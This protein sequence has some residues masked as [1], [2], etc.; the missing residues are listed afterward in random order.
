MAK[1]SGFVNK[2][3]LQV[4]I[5]AVDPTNPYPG[6]LL[7]QEDYYIF[8]NQSNPTQSLSI[9][10]LIIQKTKTGWSIRGYDQY[11]PYFTIYQ[12]IA[13]TS[14]QELRVGGISSPYTLWTANTKYVAGQ[15]VFYGDRY[16]TVVTNH[17]SG[18]TFDKVYYQ[19]LPYLP[20]VG[21]IAVSDRKRFSS[22]ETVIPYGIE[23][24]TV[25]EVYDL[26]IGY[27]AW[28]EAQGFVFDEYNNDLQKVLNWSF[29]GTEFLYWVTQGWSTD[30]IITISPF[31]N[32]LVFASD[33][34][35]VDSVTNSFYQ[36]SIL[37]ADGTPFPQE[38]LTFVRLDGQF[39]ASTVN[40]TDGIFFAR[41]NVVQK[42]HA[43]VFNNFSMFNDVVY[44]DETGYRQFRV[45]L[46]G[47][48]TANW[49]GDFFSPGFIFDEAAI[50][51]WAQYTDYTIGDVVLFNG[52][53]YSALASIPGSASFDQNQW[54]QLSQAPQP[55]LLG[56][57]DYKINQ[58]QDFY[59]LDIDNFDVAQQA[60]AQHLTGYTPR[61]YLN[62]IIGDPIAQYK[63]YQ[64]MI[65]EKGTRNA[66]SKIARA[67]L[68]NLQS[69]I[70]YNEEWAFRIGQY[71]GFNTY[72][73]LET[74]LGSAKFLENPQIIE[75]VETLP[76]NQTDA[77][78]Y[79]TA[80]DIPVQPNNFN[81][82]SVFPTTA[83][84]FT[85]NN[86]ALP[87]A[88]YVRFDDVTA[89][90]YNKN[91]VLDIASNSALM[92]GDTIWLGYKED[93]D[94]DV[95]RVTQVPT[96]I[97]MV[98]NYL[99]NQTVLITTYFPHQLS[100]NDLISISRIGSGID[101]C[102]V[103]QEIINANQFVV[104]TTLLTIPTFTS[105][106]NGL[107]FSFKSIRLNKFDDI[108][109]IPF[110][111]RWKDGELVWVDN[112]GSD[113][114]V[115]YQKINN[116][117]SSTYS[118]GII[119]LG[120][121]FGSTIVT[122]NST[123]T[124]LA[125]APS[126]TDDVGGNGRVFVLTQN[127]VTSAVTNNFSFTLNDSNGDYYTNNSN[128][129]GFGYSMAFNTVTTLTVIGAPLTSN[130]K[131]VTVGT[132]GV[133]HSSNSANSYTKQGAVKLSI[134]D[135]NLAK[136]K[137]QVV[138]TTPNPNN[139]TEFGASVYLSDNTHLLVGAPGENSAYVYNIAVNLV[140]TSSIITQRVSHTS[141]IYLSDVSE[142]E[143]GYVVT[144]NDTKFIVYSVNNDSSITLTTS[145]TGIS[146]GTIAT[147]VNV[148]GGNQIFINSSTH[149]T[150]P[151]VLDSLT[152]RTFGASVTGNADFS[153]YA[154][155]DTSVTQADGSGNLYQ[156]MVF[157]Y[158]NNTIQQI[159]TM[160]DVNLA[161]RFT[162]GDGFAS[163]ISMSKD[164]NYLAIATPQAFDNGLRSGVVDVYKWSTTGTFVWNQTVHA[165]II[166][167]DTRF[168]QTVGFNEAG[169]ILT[170]TSVG[171]SKSI[172]TTFDTYS[173]HL[174]NSL[175]KYGSGYVN[176]PASKTR[177]KQTT[178][179]SGSTKFHSTIANAGSAHVYNRSE[180]GN[181]WIYA[182]EL[183]STDVVSDS[184]FGGSVA[185]TDNLIIVGAPGNSNPI[186]SN[187]SI[188]IFEKINKESNSWLAYRQQED[189][190]DITQIKKTVTID[191]TV[192]Q[193]QD[194]IDIIDPIKGKLLGTSKQELKY[195]SLYDPAIYSLGVVG[196][197]VDSNTN[198]LDEHVGELWWDVSTVKYVWYE[199]GELDYRKNNWNNIFPGCSIDV[200]EWVRSENLPSQW[201]SLADTADGLAQGISGQP[202]FADNSVVS[203]KQV[204]SSVSNSFTNVYYFWVKNKVT[205]PANVP[206]R[207]M[208][209]FE[210]A[211]QIGD[212]V[213]SGNEFMAVIGPTALMLANFK[214]GI[215]SDKYNL[216][217]AFDADS[218]SAPRHTEWLLVQENDNAGIGNA[219]LEKKLVDS[220]VGY[221]SLGNLVPD[222]SLPT[223][224]KYGIG[225]RPQQTMFVDRFEA[226]RNIVEFSNSV[227][228]NQ[229]ITKLINFD[230]LNAKDPIPEV[231][232]Y[233]IAVEDI[234]GLEALSTSAFGTATLTSTVDSNGKIISIN[235]TN[236]GAGYIVPPLITIEGNSTAKLQSVINS[237]GQ[238]TSVTII[239]S[240]EGFVT[241]PLLLVRPFTV[242]VKTDSTIGGKWAVYQW[243]VT[244]S[245]WVR[246]RT[247]SYD[248]T[249]YWDY[250]DWKA[251]SYDPLKT[252][253]TTVPEPYVLNV[254]LNVVTGDY[255]KV[256]NDGTNNY[257]ILRKTDGTGG[258][259]DDQ[260]DLVYAQNGTIQILD[261]IWNYSS[262]ASTADY[263]WDDVGYDQTEY[264]Q[265][266]G[267]EV[268]YIL[269][270]L[271]NDIFINE[272]KVYWNQLFFKA[273]RY[274]F[275][276]QQN[277]DWAFKTTFINVVNTA[278]A[279]DQRTTYKFYN[280]DYYQQYLEEVK[281]YHT[282]IRK[283]TDN[284]TATEFTQSF[285]SDFD[286][287]AFYNTA[288][289]NFNKVE[290]GD[291]QL[292]VYPWKAWF[293]NYTCGI[294]SIEISDGGSGYTIPPTVSII[295]QSGDTGT[296]AT[297]VAYIALG[298]VSQ[299]IVT[300]PGKGYTATPMIVINGGGDTNLVKA[301]ATA[302]LTNPLVRSNMLTMKF[303]RVVSYTNTGTII[304][305]VGSKIATD[306]FIG[307]G[308]TLDFQ[309]T[310]VP[311]PDKANITLLRNGVLQLT[312]QYTINY[313]SRP[314]SPQ[315][316]TTYNKEYAKLV[317]NFI[318][319]F[320]DVIK[321]TY[322]KSLDLYTAIDR[323]EDYYAPATGMPGV[324]P[325]QLMSG[326]SFPGLNVDTLP[327]S[328]AAGWDVIPFG[329][330]AWD[331]YVQEPGYYSTST[332][333][334]GTQTFIIPQ[335]IPNGVEMNIYVNGVRIDGTA[336]GSIV[337]TLTGIGSGVVDQINVIN[338]GAGY[339][340]D[341][342]VNISSPNTLGG[343]DS[344]A[345]ITTATYQLTEGTIVINTWTNGT[346]YTST[347]IVTIGGT[348]TIPAYAQA[349]VRS[350]FV[351]NGTTSSI[352]TIPSIAFTS[353]STLIEFRYST[354]D[355]TVLPT[356]LI[357]LDV[358]LSGGNLTTSTTGF[359][360]AIGIDPNEI[361]LDGW[362]FLDPNYSY[363]PEEHV[364]GQVQESISIN[365]YTQS[366]INSPLIVNKKY[367]VDG[368]TS[369]FALGLTPVT[370]SSVVALLN[371][372]VIDPSHYYIDYNLDTFTFTAP[373]PGTGWLSLTTMQLGT[374]TV[375]D[376]TTVTDA[377]TTSTTFTSGAR[378]SEVGSSFITVNGIPTTDYTVSS[379]KGRARFT[380]LHDVNP[381]TI[382]EFSFAGTAQSFSVV[383]E[384]IIISTGT[385]TSFAL[386]YPPGN[387]GPFHSQVI[388]TKNGSR[389]PPPITTY[390]EVENNQNKFDVTSS[391][392]FTVGR[393]SL[394][395]LEVYVNGTQ[396]K[397]GKKWNLLQPQAQVE[398]KDGVLQ[399]GDLVAI[400]V[401]LDQGYLIDNNSIVLTKPAMK[402]DEFH[403]TTYTNHDPD[404]IRTERFF[405]NGAN[406]YK[407]AREI[408][409][410][411]YVWVSY[412]GTPLTVDLDYKVESDGRTIT[413][414]DGIFV[415][416]ADDVVIT[417][418]AV[419]TPTIGY[420]I[421]TDMLGR[422]QYK[423]L[424]TKGT[425]QLASTLTMTDFIISVVDASV[426]EMPNT[427]LNLP[428]I[429]NIYGERIEF[430][431]VDGNTLGQLRRG[432]LGTGVADSYPAGTPVM[433][434][435]SAQTIPYKEAMQTFT[436]VTSATTILLDSI[437]F[438]PTANAWDQ[439]EVSYA[440][441]RLLKPTTA[442]YI[443]T[444]ATIGYDS[445]DKNSAGITSTNTLP[446][447][448][449][450]DL[451]NNLVLNFNTLTNFVPLVN[452]ILTV[453]RKLGKTWYDN[454]TTTVTLAENSTPPAIFLLEGPATL[455]DKYDYGQQ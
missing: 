294:A 269:Q 389:L 396:I 189:S 100:V 192:A 74:N 38:K 196:V 234:Y 27:G 22:T 249:L 280:S 223:Q 52:L 147:F 73:E 152:S 156:G 422:T 373:N 290:L 312:D 302:R 364:P 150:A 161:G 267:V 67:S 174:E 134:L 360:T 353:T 274:A 316:N 13:T 248:T 195:I 116:Y 203:V 260:W 1:L 368:T 410:S 271:Q 136:E 78:Y 286:L 250:L 219:L 362:G 145:T 311:I 226:L 200:Y 16:Y 409:D 146:S 178:F 254:L 301:I 153:K 123:S 233:D 330:T 349:T 278:G 30:A 19:S 109:N 416:D 383:N 20:T 419:S 329:S 241:A 441:R 324:D 336:T 94:W 371:N 199:Q 8:F 412:A 400:V 104:L 309:L 165:P 358:S 162:A 444:D 449:T 370:S 120:Q 270:A 256:N 49:N 435:S 334:T 310:W 31:S 55:S 361:V 339:G 45:R 197:N 171:N 384:Q 257:I 266:P 351:Q 83:T 10:G 111:E 447:E 40:T 89:T 86:F 184:L 28:L 374:E 415:S 323:I 212:P 443:I 186:T 338:R 328:F 209:A 214:P 262:S 307:D 259:F 48:R 296:G 64:G 431:T 344:V 105:A 343:V 455:P 453:T 176:N 103:V 366:E 319:S 263:S 76:S 175:T 403:I 148:A 188:V 244:N 85:N 11:S 387:L 413:L 279:L 82:T 414:R 408:V 12:P 98:A 149:I 62:Y 297:A 304:K 264:D 386:E 352:V 423:R 168:G 207:R 202:K 181:N 222:P 61:P 418:F 17:N 24:D 102:Y 293:D 437:T 88:G 166:A 378:F 130:V 240:G 97:T 313:Y 155:S 35:V 411:Q 37:R 261:S 450:I 95:L 406:S 110:L 65:K 2:D 434:Q 258:T 454:T 93:G 342:T 227:L 238:I 211:Q 163:S 34:G 427:A 50:N 282:K 230:N 79:K 354:S 216:N 160:H 204:Y 75:F 68:F 273:V 169:N 172:V 191:T 429:I 201:S 122:G 217:I 281:P 225:I 124:I 57:F 417:S 107:L 56:N 253:V 66:V 420:R 220:I 363:A 346:G 379:Y 159:D 5:D 42:E 173:E 255:V 246:I 215:L 433:D 187:G 327:L 177:V 425:T 47:F 426:L 365:V 139:N 91:S 14:D 33:N 99:A 221:D 292:S 252:I 108:I 194:Y 46:T 245:S 25:Q 59:S 430:F 276:E 424:S 69:S 63:F 135:F 133:V 442:T 369:T 285:T 138:I 438:D 440:G 268:V 51:N 287:P 101:Q 80:S 164:G 402:F 288:T 356:D 53:Y 87:V 213:G 357:S 322:P 4:T 331:N 265:T 315:A 247:Q 140:S 158:Y 393:I 224:L 380:V 452:G 106:L 404:F 298:K 6:V 291:A 321:I 81:I 289:L 193:V 318:P 385:S 446:P 299:I 58:F 333:T 157:V 23:Y 295:A 29:S 381:V 337:K 121:H 129:T 326:L 198:W 397:P 137:N 398:F 144:L 251:S 117:S 428:G 15:I 44:D 32:T 284:Y 341:V 131:S 305:E 377:G 300:N 182:R 180:T 277:L 391:V 26:I 308:S 151:V 317:L 390:Y 113:R 205:I 325:D 439:V 320:D 237:S 399:N 283:F 451:N 303:D 142:I 92:E 242:Y 401:K 125:S 229:L 306:T 77:T 119:N 231:G 347:P 118:T 372:T 335:I 340:T 392:P 348:N 36:Y 206:N 141:T 332:I 345:S 432:T 43:L 3:K 114:W 179:D 272:L 355:A 190:V 208:A 275:T 18:A 388:V 21:G 232:T 236:P 84:T 170:I 183:F 185:V 239:N 367:Y 143:V 421:F 41:I 436:T 96:I 314:Y 154:I 90:A 235:I 376:A 9:S 39:T 115:V 7:P 218:Q 243:N 405:A 382:Q 70:D 448:F 359:T 128:P 60:M 395:V 72:S 127:P 350:S 71:G 228:Q 132:H 445:G 112:D 54:A 375:L 167:N 210:V 407:M 394:S 126:Y